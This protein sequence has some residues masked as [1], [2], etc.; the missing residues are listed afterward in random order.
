MKPQRSSKALKAT[1][2]A[3]LV[4]Q[5]DVQF[6]VTVSIYSYG[7]RSTD[8][9]QGDAQRCSTWQAATSHETLSQAVQ[10][11]SGRHHERAAV[12]CAGLLAVGR[13]SVQP[14]CTGTPPLAVSLDYTALLDQSLKTTEGM[15]HV[16]GCLAACDPDTQAACLQVSSALELYQG[17]TPFPWLTSGLCGILGERRTC[18]PTLSRR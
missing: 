5:A 2:L 16:A 4:Y 3:S 9:Y 18:Q 17:T 1:P 13:R 12:Q 11:R 6:T 7:Q 8:S 10:T 15:I 14:A